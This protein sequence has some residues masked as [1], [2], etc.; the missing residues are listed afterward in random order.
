MGTPPPGKS[1]RFPDCRG[2]NGWPGAGILVLDRAA[3]EPVFKDVAHP[4][5]LTVESL[6]VA[7]GES[8]HHLAQCLRRVLQHKVH[9]VLHK[10]PRQ[11]VDSSVF[12]PLYKELEK[13]TAIGI[14][15]KDY[16]PAVSAQNHVVEARLSSC[17]WRSRHKDP[18][19]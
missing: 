4:P 17:P 2:R 12:R 18:L 15:L 13:S 8:L 1:R 5:R 16:L 11:N 10:A 3:F 19:P 14:V 9:V 7:A 6:R